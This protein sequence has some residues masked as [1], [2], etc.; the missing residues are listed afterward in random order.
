MKRIFFTALLIILISAASFARKLVAEGKTFTALGNFKIETAD[1]PLVLN[2]IEL[3]TFVITYENS[4]MNVTI[5]IDEDS[6]CRRFLTI[7]DKLS[8]QYVCTGSYFGIEKL[9]KKYAKEGLKTHDSALNRSA[10]FHQKIIVPGKNDP[11]YCM[12]LI[13]AYYPELINDLETSLQAN[14]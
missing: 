2:G 13:A 9:H 10:Y 8:V 1:Q 3:K 6:N 14:K 5:A 4:T 11:V 7:S 12:K